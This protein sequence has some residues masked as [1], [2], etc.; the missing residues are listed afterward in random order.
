[1]F[2][3]LVQHTV[4]YYWWPMDRWENSKGMKLHHFFRSRTAGDLTGARMA[5]SVAWNGNKSSRFVRCQW[6]FKEIYPKKTWRNPNWTYNWINMY[7][8]TCVVDGHHKNMDHLQVRFFNSPFFLTLQNSEIFGVAFWRLPG[9]MLTTY[10]KRSWFLGSG[11][12]GIFTL[13]TMTFG[14]LFQ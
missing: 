8:S 10:N 7:R 5:T 14:G 11:F 13:W 6:Y 3:Q 2:F 9:L 4:G 12:C 1:M